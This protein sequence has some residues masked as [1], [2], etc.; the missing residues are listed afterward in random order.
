M[1]KIFLLLVVILLSACYYEDPVL[2][3]LPEYTQK[4]LY[5]EGGFQDYTDYGIYTFAPFPEIQLKENLYFELVSDTGEI[6]SYVENFEGWVALSDADGELVQKYDFDK[7]C[8]DVS[9][10]FYL[11]TK[12]GEPI[13]KRTYGKFECYDLYLF[14]MDTNTLY[15]FHS[16]I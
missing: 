16:N 3:T 11:D 10:Y 2:N 12:E 9:D 14:D 15:Y 8:I 4:E 5:S 1:K 6:L 13:G 7:S